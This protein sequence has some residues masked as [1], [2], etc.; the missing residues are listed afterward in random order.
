MNITT[1]GNYFNDL[2]NIVKTL[3]LEKSLSRIWNMDE[4][5]CQLEHTPV[6]VCASKGSKNVPGVVSNSRESVTILP[7]INAN[8]QHMSP[9]MIV[10][11]K[12]EKSLN[13][14]NPEDVLDVHVLRQS[15]DRRG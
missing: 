4:T 3:N 8:G 15:M 11:G 6:A 13:G 9:M 14:F 7:C 1:L 5:E 2:S 12:T 10:R